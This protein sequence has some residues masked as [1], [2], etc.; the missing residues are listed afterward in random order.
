[1]VKIPT[2]AMKETQTPHRCILVMSQYS[3]SII[4]TDKQLLKSEVRNPFD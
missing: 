4:L 3:I 1:M 2:E